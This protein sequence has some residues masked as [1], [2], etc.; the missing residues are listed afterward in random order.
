MTTHTHIGNDTLEV[1]L[2]AL[3]IVKENDEETLKAFLGAS[4][5]LDYLYEI[6]ATGITD[7]IGEYEISEIQTYLGRFNA[8]TDIKAVLNVV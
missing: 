2:D 7:E 8:K 3:E 1:C 5:D 6:M 4:L